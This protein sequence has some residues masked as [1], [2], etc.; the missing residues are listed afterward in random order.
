MMIY[1]RE[2]TQILSPFIYIIFYWYRD[3]II[4]FIEPIF[5]N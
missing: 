4:D 2:K 1:L 3:V 5:I